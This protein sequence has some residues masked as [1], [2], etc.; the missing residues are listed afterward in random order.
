MDEELQRQSAADH[1]LAPG[2]LVGAASGPAAPE[3]DRCLE[4]RLGLVASREDQRLGVAGAED[5]QRA[6]AGRGRELATDRLGV[7][8]GAPGVPGAD[9][10]RVGTGARDR[11]R[12][13]AG[14]S[15]PG[16]TRSR[17]AARAASASAPL[18][19]F[20]RPGGP[21]RAAGARPPRG[22]VIASV[23]RTRPS[24]G[25][26][27]RLEH[28]GIRQVAPLRAEGDG[29]RE[30]QAAAPLLVEKGAEHAWRVEVRQAEPVDRSVACDQRG[31]AAVADH[32]VVANRWLLVPQS[33]HSRLAFH[34]QRVPGSHM[35]G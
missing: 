9:G 17:S 20:P 26:E 5:E 15:A 33:L 28:V 19:R 11:R 34:L 7:A 16:A 13:R 29:R 21:A 31:R 35:G 4:P 24:V 18:R 22:R 8:D 14:R 12:R 30:Q 1:R 6:R 2:P 25:D 27:G 32:A 23:T 3:V 10:E